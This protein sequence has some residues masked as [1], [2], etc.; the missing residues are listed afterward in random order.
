MSVYLISSLAAVFVAS[1][2]YTLWLLHK[3]SDERAAV[4]RELAQASIDAAQA[5][6]DKT[7][8]EQRAMIAKQ[9]LSEKLRQDREAFHKEIANA[10][11]ADLARALRRKLLPRAGADDDTPAHGV[12]AGDGT[13]QPRP[14]ADTDRLGPKAKR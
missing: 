10:D 4:L 3:I 12:G 5:I 6:A 13:V 11:V 8:A 14:L 7:H 9:T 2:S 1:T